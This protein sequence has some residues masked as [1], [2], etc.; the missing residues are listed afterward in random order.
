MTY[1][2]AR[3]ETAEEMRK[4]LHFTLPDER[5]CAA[6]ATLA[7]DLRPRGCELCVANRLWGQA[8][9][10]FLESFL[11]LTRD[12][13]GAELEQVDFA[14]AAEAARRT[15]N[16]WA[17]KETRERIGE[18][19]EPDILDPPP[20][21]VL[22]NA[23]YFKGNWAKRFSKKKTKRARFTL[24]NGD[25]VQVRIMYQKEKFNYAAERGLQVLEMPYRRGDLSMFVFL[26]EKPDG[27]PE[28]E[29]SL[30]G[31][32]L[33]VW[34]SHLRKQKVHVYMPRFT[35]TSRFR[36]KETLKSMGMRLAFSG[37]DFSGIGG[38]GLYIS[39]VVHKAFVEVNEEGTE[40]AAATAVAAPAEPIL[41]RAD[42]PFLFLILENRSGSILFLG[43]VMNPLG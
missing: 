18:L 33:K 13:Y 4:A 9:Y 21:L 3:G 27:L 32:N 17:K 15:I 29:G 1:A 39:H 36:L 37:A 6:F 42:H 26:P 24:P 35:I 10:P 7:C 25:K 14:G 19:I 11:K 22:T 8:G 43:R 16:A 5:L 12:Y 30:N 2:G 28:F 23:I 41:F 20:V 40:A 34:L 38:P 31:E